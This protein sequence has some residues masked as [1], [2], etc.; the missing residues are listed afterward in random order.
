MISRRQQTHTI[1]MT[2]QPLC[3][4][5]L[6]WLTLSWPSVWPNR[7]IS[8]SPTETQYTIPSPSRTRYFA[9]YEG[10][11]RPDSSG[12]SLMNHTITVYVSF[13]SPRFSIYIDVHFNN[14][15]TFFPCPPNNQNILE[16]EFNKLINI[17][18]CLLGFVSIVS[19]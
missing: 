9:I 1:K 13:T 3:I 5:S 18:F 2:W 12:K 17:Y 6:Q 10:W 19:N 7:G 4:Y 14:K 8:S 11:A 15:I 16:F